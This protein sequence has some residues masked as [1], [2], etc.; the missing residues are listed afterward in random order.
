MDRLINSRSA[1]IKDP[2]T[3]MRNRS[4]SVKPQI[5]KQ[6]NMGADMRRVAK[7][8][9]R[10]NQAQVTMGVE[11]LEPDSDQDRDGI[12]W[13][14]MNRISQMMKSWSSKNLMTTSNMDKLLR[15]RWNTTISWTNQTLGIRTSKESSS[16]HK[17]F[18]SDG[19]AI[20]TGP[21][22]VSLETRW[23][24]GRYSPL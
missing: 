5:Q 11:T 1:A 24:L 14:W 8:I 7:P 22:E 16:I 3:T 9:R 4:Q 19:C 21:E 17:S 6:V 20:D 18:V 15:R 12:L 10:L 2:S 23:V 13:M